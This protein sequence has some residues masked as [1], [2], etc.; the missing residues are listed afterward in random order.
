MQCVIV[1]SLVAVGTG[2]FVKKLG[3]FKK[4]LPVHPSLA[5]R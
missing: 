2:V 5:V 3:V 1:H 4:H